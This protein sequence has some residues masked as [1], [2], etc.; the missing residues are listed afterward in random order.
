VSDD[1]PDPDISLIMA[2]NS[3]GIRPDIH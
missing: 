2:K 3:Q 1:T